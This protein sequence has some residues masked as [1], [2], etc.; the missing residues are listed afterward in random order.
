MK[1]LAFASALALSF[2]SLAAAELNTLTPQEKADGWKL[3]FD[4]KSLTGWRNFKK[5]E[6]PKQGWVAEDGILKKVAAVNGGDIIT[7]QTFDDFDLEWDWNISPKGNN[8]I[9]YF[10][11]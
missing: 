7:Y 6:P 5:K 11:S 8:G 2:V 4:G 3:L 9:K 1:S 10:V